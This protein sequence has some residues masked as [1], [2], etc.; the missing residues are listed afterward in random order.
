MSRFKLPDRK[1]ILTRNADGGYTTTT[2]FGD[3]REVDNICLHHW[4]PC[5][6]D[7][8]TTQRLLDEFLAEFPDYEL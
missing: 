3:G 4:S 2:R 7:Y 8:R 6:C 1:V 5:D